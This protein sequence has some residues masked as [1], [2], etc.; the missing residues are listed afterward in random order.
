MVYSCNECG[1]ES[2]YKYQHEKHIKTHEKDGITM[3]NTK[4]LVHINMFGKKICSYETDNEM[5]I[6]KI[7]TL[8]KNNAKEVISEILPV[9]F[10]PNTNRRFVEGTSEDCKRIVE[11]LIPAMYANMMIKREQN[12]EW[13]NSDETRRKMY[14]KF[15]HMMRIYEAYT[16]GSELKRQRIEKSDIFK[17]LEAFIAMTKALVDDEPDDDEDD[18]ECEVRMMITYKY[19]K[20]MAKKA[21]LDKRKRR[22]NELICL[23]KDKLLKFDLS[24]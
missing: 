11:V 24:L 23:I 19:K 5:I 10:D 7:S 6:Q 13:L 12:K 18:F 21:L 16:L 3:H 20:M 22:E 9:L 4:N 15:E 8:N 17:Y 14:S 1:F 2:R